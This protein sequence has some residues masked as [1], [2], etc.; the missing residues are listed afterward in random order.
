MRYYTQGD[1]IYIFGFSRGAYTARF[2]SKMIHSIGLLSMGNEEMIYFAWEAFSDFQT[3]QNTDAES[4]RTEALMNQF[5]SNFC[6]TGEVAGDKVQVH[7]LGLFDCVNSVAAFLSAKD[8]PMPMPHEEKTIV[9]PAKHVRHAVSIHERRAMFQPVLFDP[10]PKKGA[11]PTGLVE[12]WFAGNHGD[13]GG[14]W[15][16]YPDP[17]GKESYLLSDIPLGWMIEQVKRVD[18]ASKVRLNPNQ[19]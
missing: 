14:G 11:G 13:V 1:K 15:K 12:R 3:N 5:K 18:E 7:F 4:D 16:S 9:L 17:E 6:R 2:L 19:K 10:D 8:M